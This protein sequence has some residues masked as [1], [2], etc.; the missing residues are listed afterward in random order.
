[1]CISE[2]PPDIEEEP[3]AEND[4]DNS[5]STTINVATQKDITMMTIGKIDQEKSA[6]KSGIEKDE[7]E[8]R[9]EK[10]L[11]DLYKDSLDYKAD[12]AE[13][14]KETRKPNDTTE[15]TEKP[16]LRAR[17]N[18]KFQPDSNDPREVAMFRTS[19]DEITCRKNKLSGV[20]TIP[21]SRG[22]VFSK[23]GLYTIISLQYIHM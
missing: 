9:I 6:R 3:S 11:A 8:A 2:L 12:S 23:I 5:T 10:E 7:D 14:V 1:M 16:I 21:T 17:N 22:T 13:I 19:I 15:S 20:T 4:D 18:F